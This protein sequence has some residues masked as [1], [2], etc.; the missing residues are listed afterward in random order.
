L[1]RAIHGLLL[2]VLLAL[3]P[4][5]AQA[6]LL[7]GTVPGPRSILPDAAKANRLARYLEDRLEQEVAVLTFAAGD[8]LAAWLRRNARFETA[9]LRL[10]RS[11]TPTGAGRFFRLG[12]SSRT[13]QPSFDGGD[14]A[15]LKEQP[16]AD[17]LVR[18]QQALVEMTD[19][20]AGRQL[21]DDLDLV[22]ILPPGRPLPSSEN[23]DRTTGS[24][25][26]PASRE[27]TAAPAG[28]DFRSLLDD[29]QPAH[30]VYIEPFTAVMVPAAVEETVFDDFVDRL[31]EAGRNSGYGFAILKGGA[32]RKD[33][34]WLA[35]HTLVSGEVF[36]Y[37]EDSGCCN[38]EIRVRA[39]FRLRRPCESS[40]A[41]EFEAPF[42]VFFDHDRST[43]QQER[44]AL[45]RRMAAALAD[46]LLERL[47]R[48]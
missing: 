25:A 6:R 24:E 21:L 47:V 27:S 1:N 39:R 38:T 40:P 15:I 48:P 12:K 7:V 18:V 19:S 41:F 14:L 4:T 8:D 5:P 44:S 11:G 10:E 32:S 33:A 34:A 9:V 23:P 37:V 45:A 3:V 36:G 26:S 42:E 29:T 2:V 20:A 46:T 31:N 28:S 13:G 16:E 35:S 22:A 30:L 43:L 17:L